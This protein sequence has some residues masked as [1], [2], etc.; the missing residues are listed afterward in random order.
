MP[1]SPFIMLIVP[2][3]GA[4]SPDNIAN[5]VLFPAPLAPSNPKHYK[6]RRNRDR[7]F[8]EN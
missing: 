3:V 1:F 4:S 5:M 6:T 2:D 7:E 8:L